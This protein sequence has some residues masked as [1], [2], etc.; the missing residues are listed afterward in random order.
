MA[1][2]TAHLA[3]GQPDIYHGGI[4]PTHTLWLSEKSRPAWILDCVASAT[5][6]GEEQLTWATERVTWV[7]SRPEHILEDGLLMIALHVLRS[8]PATDFAVKHCPELLEAEWFDL[9]VN[10]SKLP[11][12]TLREMARTADER[13]KL[14]VSVLDDSST[15]EQLRVLA[16]YGMELEILTPA[17]T[18][19]RGWD[20]EL[21]V[22][23]AFPRSAISYERAVE[24][25][26]RAHEGQVDKDG[27]TY[28]LH[29]LRVSMAVSEE[30]RAV[31]IL[32]DVIEDTDVDAEALF[33][34]L[35]PAEATAL[36]LLTRREEHSYEAFI[37]RMVT[38][39]GYGAELAR[40]IKRAD[41]LD[42]LGRMRVSD[43]PEWVER[44]E[45]YEA[46]L[47][48]LADRASKE[49]Q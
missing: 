14:V 1:A 4:V 45:R 49:P 25:A 16:D 31:A 34:E 2:F 3:I 33:A 43:E 47:V 19:L 44:R 39:D 40:E 8:E 29:P 12:A 41:I 46:A 30:A 17:Y 9:N 13:Y 36:D 32:H 11:L 37:E 5:E 48:R 28:L 18:R 24:I 6:P 38:F 15:A 27:V 7:P 23:G 10:D 26:S 21:T 22:T 35:A 42:N 20:D